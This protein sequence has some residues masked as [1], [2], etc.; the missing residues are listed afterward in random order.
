MPTGRPHISVI[1]ATRDR[2]QFL[3][4]ALACYQHQTWP[5]TDRELIVIDDGDQFPVADHAV[6]AVGGRLL[7][8]PPGTPLGSKLNA[9]IA[10]ARGRFIQKMDDDDWY[11]ASFLEEMQA[12]LAEAWKDRCHPALLFLSPFLFFDLAAWELRRS[13]PNHLPGATLHFPRSLWEEHPF[14]P[15]FGDEDTWF[16]LDHRRRG[17]GHLTC[18]ARDT[19]LAVRHTTVTADRAHTW[20]HQMSGSL[21]EDYTSHLVL[22]PRQPD[23]LLPA[24]AVMNY[25]RIRTGAI[26]PPPVS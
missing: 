25:Q 1:L 12:T 9:G 18:A 21:L 23:E 13:V 26:E 14:R 11:G 7:R 2:P 17:A 22:D 5:S 15:L 6:E 8:V 19:F 3:A 20:T 16:L 4:L 10:V 24:W